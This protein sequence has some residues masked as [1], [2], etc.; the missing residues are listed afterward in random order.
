MKAE[1]AIYLP[2]EDVKEQTPDYEFAEK[3]NSEISTTLFNAHI[4]KLYINT[5]DFCKNLSYYSKTELAQRYILG[6]LTNIING[7]PVT[8]RTMLDS[9]FNTYAPAL[10]AT[11]EQTG[12]NSITAMKDAAMAGNINAANFITG[13]ANGLNAIEEEKDLLLKNP[14]YGEEIPIDIVEKC[15]FGYNMPAVEHKVPLGKSAIDYIKDISPVEMEIDAHVKNEYAEV[16]AMNDFSNKIVDAML[17]KEF[18]I[19]RIGKTIYE[20]VIVFEY[21]PE[22]TNIYDITFTLKLK[23]GY[24]LGRESRLNRDGLWT[25]NS[26]IRSRVFENLFGSSEYLGQG[27]VEK[28]YPWETTLIE[29]AKK[30]LGRDKITID[31][32]EL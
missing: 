32:Q 17:K 21:E 26:G 20:D 30:T 6:A 16:W 19:L 24:N 15:K 12:Y 8:N 11:L 23:Y 4:Q 14:K 18:V 28:V 5:R 10:N 31:G 27:R 25:V 22:I 3:A 9:L 2:I 13:F 1:A 7:E 29:S